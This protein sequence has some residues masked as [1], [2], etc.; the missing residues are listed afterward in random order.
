MAPIYLGK[1]HKCQN[2][3]KRD[4]KLDQRKRETEDKW[5]EKEMAVTV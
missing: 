4:Q 1:R 5:G 3:E 2:P